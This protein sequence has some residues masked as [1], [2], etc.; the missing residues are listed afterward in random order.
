ML[1]RWGP[2][3]E[4]MIQWPTYQ[5]TYYEGMVHKRKSRHDCYIELRSFIETVVIY[6]FTSRRMSA[7]VGSELW[8]TVP[9]S[10][11]VRTCIWSRRRCSFVAFCVL[12]ASIWFT[13]TFMQGSPFRSRFS[14]SHAMPVDSEQPGQRHI[15][16]PES[17]RIV[18][19]GA[20]IVELLSL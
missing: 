9:W 3:P 8:R 16:Q 4:V 13:D 18:T 11:P 2:M 19:F 15:T 10:W 20:R 14:S 12:Q 6:V 1:F 5:R 7:L 17:A